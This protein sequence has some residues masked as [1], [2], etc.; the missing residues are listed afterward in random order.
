MFRPRFALGLPLALVAALAPSP[1]T[2][3]EGPWQLRAGAA[4]LEADA[5]LEATIFDVGSVRA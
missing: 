1:A 5:E 4:W 2:A 3:G